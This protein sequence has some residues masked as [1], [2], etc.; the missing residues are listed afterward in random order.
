MRSISCSMYSPT[1]ARARGRELLCP[2]ST[3]RFS[4]YVHGILRS[5]Q[6]ASLRLRFAARARLRLSRPFPEGFALA[7]ATKRLS[8]SASPVS[9]LTT[10]AVDIKPWREASSDAQSFSQHVLSAERRAALGPAAGHNASNHQPAAIDGAQRDSTFMGHGLSRDI[11][12]WRTAPSDLPSS[13]HRGPGSPSCVQS[14][15]RHVLPANLRA[16]LGTAPSYRT[17][18]H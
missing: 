18:K 8:R 15:S 4:A 12:L 9:R 1:N 14:S 6:A 3:S 16:T 2:F 13:L 10:S 7:G 11:W 17:S 5:W